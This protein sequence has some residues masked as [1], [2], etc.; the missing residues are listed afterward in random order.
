MLYK[1]LNHEYFSTI[2]TNLLKNIIIALKFTI[3]YILRK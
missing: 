3:G 2:V 1:D